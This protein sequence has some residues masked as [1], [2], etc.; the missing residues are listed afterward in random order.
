MSETMTMGTRVKLSAM[1]FLQFMMFAVWWAALTVYMTNQGD[2][3]TR[4]VPWIIATQGFGSLAAP[5]MGMLADRYFNGEKVLAFSN[6]LCA[7]MLFM[8]ARATSGVEVF[9]Y[10]L[11][12]MLFYMPTWGLTAAIAMANSPAEQFPQIRVFGTIGWVASVLFG[13]VAVNVFGTKID[14][15]VIPFYCG[16]GAAL[17]AAGVALLCPATPPKGKG[18]PF[19]PVDALGLKAASM[20]KD[21]NF[22][23]FIMVTLVAMIPFNI[24]FA[25]IGDFL[26]A[27]GFQQVTAVAYIGQAAEVFCILAVTWAMRKFGVKWSI[28]AG[29]AA[30]AIRYAAYYFAAGSMTELVYIGILIHGIVFGFLVV[31]GQVYVGKTAKPEMQGQAQGFYAFVAF[32]IGSIIGAFA[33]DALIN[34]FTEKVAQEGGTYLKTGQWDKVWLVTLACSVICLVVMALLFNP[35]EDKQEAA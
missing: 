35:K 13:F 15:T 32:G 29:L 30:L 8:A 4:W 26:A 6:A 18:Q 20:L 10:L 33:N 11:I 25:Y 2:A 17:V 16:A 22:F 31:G 27:K 1:M 12:A 28:V 23:V 14:G 19:S 21:K 3:W 7:V 34:K 9:V 5:L 24:H